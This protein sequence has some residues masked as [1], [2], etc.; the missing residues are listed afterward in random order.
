[1]FDLNLDSIETDLPWK[2]LLSSIDNLDQRK[3]E[4][5]DATAK[6]VAEI[7]S[8]AEKG[9]DGYSGSS[10]TI[11][12]WSNSAV[13]HLL[14]VYMKLFNDKNASI[15]Q[16]EKVVL[17]KVLEEGVQKMNSALNELNESWM[18]YGKSK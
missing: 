1:M 6:I 4:Y 9:A 2:K 11:Y 3:A 12:D 5:S 16:N 14:K 10:R 8:L 15:I 18:R 17:I 13:Q 7:K